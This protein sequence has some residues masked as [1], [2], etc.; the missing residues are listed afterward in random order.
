MASALDL[1]WRFLYKMSPHGRLMAFFSA[2][3]WV[4]NL[5]LNHCSAQYLRIHWIQDF[6]ECSPPLDLSYTAHRGQEANLLR[7]CHDA[8]CHPS[9]QIFLVPWSLSWKASTLSKYSVYWS[10]RNWLQENLYDVVRILQ[11]NAEY[12][13]QGILPQ[14]CTCDSIKVRGK[15]K[16]SY[17]FSEDFED[18][19]V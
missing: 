7:C 2:Y 19:S 9:L 5:Y 14:R 1:G 16:R 8:V 4:T 13:N 18:K 3:S 15:G 17:V 11:M 6:A 10:G 12:E